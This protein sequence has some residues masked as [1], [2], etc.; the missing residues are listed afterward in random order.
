MSEAFSSKV[1]Q[2]ALFQFEADFADS[3]RCIP[4]CVR[5]K[6]D[7]CGVKLKLPHWN[8]LT[9]PDRETLVTLPCTTEPEIAAYRS[10]L[11]QLVQAHSNETPSDLPIDPQPD[12]LNVSTIPDS[13]QEQGE[14]VGVQLTLDQWAGLTPIQRFA[15][16]KLSRSQHENKNFL[17]ALQEFQLVETA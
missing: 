1:F 10:H 16:I 11:H 3:L 4:M 7:T 9:Q 5:Y 12:W 17:P 14:K 13:V 6:L 2:P 15:L 8:Q